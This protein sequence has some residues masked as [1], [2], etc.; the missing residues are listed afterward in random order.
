M[1]KWLYRTHRPHIDNHALF[2]LFFFCGSRAAFLDKPFIRRS[3]KHTSASICSSGGGGGGGGRVTHSP[4]MWQN[5]GGEEKRV[6]AEG[7][8]MSAVTSHNIWAGLGW[9][10]FRG[11]LARQREEWQSRAMHHNCNYVSCF[12]TLCIKNKKNS[13]RENTV[14]TMNRCLKVKR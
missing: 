7:R 9:V 1:F 10:G 5:E 13:R 3:W 4:H 6:G 11:G 12:Y 14:W 2:L 8:M